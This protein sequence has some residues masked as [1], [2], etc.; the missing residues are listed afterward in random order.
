MSH[1]PGNSK[2]HVWSPAGVIKPYDHGRRTELALSKEREPACWRDLI[3]QNVSGAGLV[4]IFRGVSSPNVV[5]LVSGLEV[6]VA[7]WIP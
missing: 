3:S 7:M 5:A 2:D 6:L 4:A 1:P